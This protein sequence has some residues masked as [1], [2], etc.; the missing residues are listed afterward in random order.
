MAVLAFWLSAVVVLSGT[1]GMDGVQQDSCV[2]LCR[3]M[4]VCH[5]RCVYVWCML[6]A[7]TCSTHGMSALGRHSAVLF[8]GALC[9]LCVHC[10]SVW[11]AWRVTRHM[12]VGPQLG[13]PACLWLN[14]VHVLL[15]ALWR[16]EG[17]SSTPP[18]LPYCL[19]S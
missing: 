18:C 2:V 13:S 9:Q 3:C 6:E 15:A 4:S 11:A 1:C 5:T 19:L 10:S 8:V 17:A 14:L 16:L 7:A 12:L